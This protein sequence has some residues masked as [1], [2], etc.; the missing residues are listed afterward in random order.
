MLGF[1]LKILEVCRMMYIKKFRLD[2]INN[3]K[4]TKVAYFQ[5]G[6]KFRT[7]GGNDSKNIANTKNGLIIIIVIVKVGKK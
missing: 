5:P 6:I 7:D 4:Q 1:Y 2:G 3:F